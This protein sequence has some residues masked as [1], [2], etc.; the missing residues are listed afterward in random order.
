MRH[1]TIP[2]AIKLADESK[3]VVE[4]Q[5]NYPQLALLAIKEH[6]PDLEWVES[7]DGI[8]SVFGYS[9]SSPERKESW[10]ILIRP[11]A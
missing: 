9:S 2:Q 5:H 3:V 10:S 11:E 4:V 6:W 8:I 7:P 1:L